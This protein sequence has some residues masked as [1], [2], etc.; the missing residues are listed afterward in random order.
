M[1]NVTT[2]VVLLAF[3]FTTL[4]EEPGTAIALVVILL[5]G[6]VL[7]FWWKSRRGVA[8]TS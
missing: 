3:A 7:D 4:V 1:A 8:P 2:I 5:L 6:V